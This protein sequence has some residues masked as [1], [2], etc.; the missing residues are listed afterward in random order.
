V[1]N[2]QRK[3]V[4]APPVILPKAGKLHGDL[5]FEEMKATR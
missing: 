1:E 3:K 4:D 2:R 5:S